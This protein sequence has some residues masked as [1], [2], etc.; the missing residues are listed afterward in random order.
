MRKHHAARRHLESMRDE[1]VQSLRRPFRVEVEAC[2]DP[3]DS[4]MA[5]I[6]RDTG[7]SHMQRTADLYREVVGAIDRIS[8]GQYG[9]CEECGETISPRRLKALP[10]AS[11]C[12]SCQSRRERAAA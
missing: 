1:L 4:L 8:N 2:A 10:Y 3:I 9:I 7:L 11:L 6:G 5:S 12:I